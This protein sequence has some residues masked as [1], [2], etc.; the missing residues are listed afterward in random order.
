MYIDTSCYLVAEHKF[1]LYGALYLMVPGTSAVGPVI[2]A[3]LANNSEPYYRRG[4]SVSMGIISANSVGFGDKYNNFPA[5]FPIFQG[6]ILSIWCYP[7]N[8]GPKFKK[9]TVMNLSL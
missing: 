5:Q 2:S 8:E 3:W 6:G 7:T 4:T 9:T 1:T